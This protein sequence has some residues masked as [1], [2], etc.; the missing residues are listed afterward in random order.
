L[1]DP[2]YTKRKAAWSR[3]EMLQAGKEYI[4]R[5]NIVPSATDFHPGDCRYSARISFARGRVWLE[6]AARFEDGLYP[7]PR[8]VMKEFGSWAAY[9]RALGHE[10]RRQAIPELSHRAPRVDIG[11]VRRLAA[12]AV[13][14]KGDARRVALLELVDAAV[15]LLEAP[16]TV[17]P[18]GR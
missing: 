2:G 1:P 5:F 18:S 11:G 13:A 15:A 8:T 6:R 9:I 10:P 12:D 16:D 4:E 17:A 7:W 3:E 14:L